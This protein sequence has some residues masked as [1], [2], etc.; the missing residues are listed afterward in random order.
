[1]NI[2]WPELNEENYKIAAAN[3][4]SKKN[5]KQRYLDNGWT[6]EKAITKPLKK[7]TGLWPEWKEVCESNGVSNELFNIRLRK[8][9]TPEKSATTPKGVGRSKGLWKE[10]KEQAEAAGIKAATFYSRV[11]KGTPPEEA[12]TIPVGAWGGKNNGFN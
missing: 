7:E 10:Y 5:V 9:N 8:G 1:M 12:A 2:E 4:I 11:R 3:G 6:I